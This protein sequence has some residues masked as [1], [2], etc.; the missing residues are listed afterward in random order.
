MKLILLGPP[1]SGKGTQA[2]F[3][4][5]RFQI[6]VISTGDIIRAQLKSG[7]EEG[8]KLKSYIDQ[9]ELVPDDLV[10]RIVEDRLA[11]PDCQNGFILD[12]FP[13]TVAQAQAL[14]A[15]G[16]KVDAVIDIAL[17]DEIIVDRL[18]GRRVCPSCGASYHTTVI[19]SANG[20]HCDRCGSELVQRNDDTPAVIRNRLAVY[21]ESTAPLTAYYRAEGK[22]I[23]ISSEGSVEDVK[24]AIFGA[25]EALQ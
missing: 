2:A 17:P 6:P 24:A 3:I 23:P 22:V 20:T 4:R 18:S 5:D 12:G 15:M 13:R 21:G 16:T 7:S 9:G 1:G 10:I 8:L 11:Q 19:P 25:L 14:E